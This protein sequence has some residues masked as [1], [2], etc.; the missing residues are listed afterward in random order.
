MGE[1]YVFITIR[2]TYRKIRTIVHF[3]KALLL[4][5]VFVTFNSHSS[6]YEGSTVNE[7][8]GLLEAQPYSTLPSNEVSYRQLFDG[9]ISLIERSANRTLNEQKDIIPYFSKLAHPNGVC[10]RGVWSIDKENTY[11][12]L[13]KKGS[14]AIIIARA[15]VALNETEAGDLRAFGLAGKIFPT[16]NERAKVKTA[17][18][19]VID[20]LSGTRAEHYTDVEMTN[21]PKTSANST[22]LKY[23]R[24]A[25]EVASTFRKVD[26]HPGIRQVYEIAQANLENPN[27]LKFPKW[28]M[29]KASSKQLQIN[30]ADFRNELDIKLNRNNI[31]FDILIAN[32]ENSGNKDWKKIG[33]IKFNDSVS[34]SAC[35]HQLHF[36]HP[37][38][39]D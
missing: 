36:H 27:L 9:A 38:W 33:T 25:L 21:E 30:E 6:P 11:S 22:I 18:F 12:G 39:K 2:M 23:L 4:S 34:S 15:S 32:S 20:D 8:W 28:M 5:L 31:S 16:M 13:F 3:M 35:D 19:F 24:Y 14:E 26:S 10:L 17:N 1:K 7:V 29:I 37:K